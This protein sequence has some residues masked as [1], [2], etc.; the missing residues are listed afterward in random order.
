MPKYFVSKY[1]DPKVGLIYI[2]FEDSW[3]AVRPDGETSMG[4]GELSAD[5]LA[6]VKEIDAQEAS[7][8]I[9]QRHA[10]VSRYVE[11][12]RPYEPARVMT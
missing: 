8:L 11:P 7:G 6:K 4:T 10:D 5:V 2:Q 12:D 1:L 9:A 3:N